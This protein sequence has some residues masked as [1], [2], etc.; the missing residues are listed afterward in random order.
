MGYKTSDALSDQRFTQIVLR[1]DNANFKRN[2]CL[3]VPG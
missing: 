2:L 3:T 1:R